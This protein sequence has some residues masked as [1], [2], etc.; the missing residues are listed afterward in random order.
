M[1][2]VVRGDLP[3]TIRWF[4]D[5]RPLELFGTQSSSLGGS[6]DA[7][8]ELRAAAGGLESAGI[9][10]KHLDP[11]S[12]TLTFGSLQSHHRGQY[13]CEATNE[14]GRASQSSLLVIHGKL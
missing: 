10:V 4:K 2:T 12:S 7:N 14:A 9:A 11:Y 5:G 8:D 3:V 6:V 1:C 13:L